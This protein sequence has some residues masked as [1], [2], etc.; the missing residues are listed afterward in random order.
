MA[1]APEG[2]DFSF[3]WESFQATCNADLSNNLGNFV[4][5]VIRFAESRYD[6]RVPA[7]GVPAELEI[8]LFR[9]IDERL[10]R[11]RRFHEALDF[12]KAASETR[13]LWTLG[14]EY[15]TA[16]APWKT[17]KSNLEEAGLAI[18]IG[19]NLCGLFAR[20]SNPF[21]PATAERIADSVNIKLDGQSWPYGPASSLLD[22]LPYRSEIRALP[23]LFVRI[24][25]EW[26]AKQTN[27]FNGQVSEPMITDNAL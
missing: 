22:S 6:G 20:I 5:R 4:N 16:S 19:L 11:L 21:I 10:K 7:G 15:L 2:G 26:V 8:K 25:D 12:K 1:N 24:D 17:I 3:T 23:V 18:R 27:T 13:A 9:E 14:N